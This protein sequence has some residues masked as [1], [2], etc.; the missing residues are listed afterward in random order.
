MTVRSV[1]LLAAGLSALTGQAADWPLYRGSLSQQGVSEDT[2]PADPV[3]LWSFK[4]EAPITSSPVVKDGT[5]VV[6][7][8]DGSVYA[9]SLDNGSKRWSFAT[10]ADVEAPPA[11]VD[12][13]VAVGSTDGFLYGLNLSDGALRWK[14]ETE[15]SILAAAVPLVVSNQVRIAVGSYDYR[16]HCVEA[17]GGKLLWTYE[18]D[19]YINGSPAVDRGQAVF[20]GCDGLLHVVDLTTGL[21]VKSVEVDAYIAGSAALVDG[22]AYFGHYGNRFVAIRVDDGTALWEYGDRDF[23]FFSAP[24]VGKDRVFFG[25]RDKRVHAVDRASGKGLWTFRTRGK[26]DSSPV[27]AGDRLVVGS[28][29]GRLYILDADTGSSVWSYDIASAIVGAPAV[30]DGRILVGAEDGTLYVFGRPENR[31]SPEPVSDQALRFHT[32]PKPLAPGAVTSEWPSF[33][34][35]LQAMKSLESPLL[36]DWG[37]G[38]PALVWERETGEGFSSPALAAGRLVTFHRIGDEDVV[39]CLEPATGRRYWSRRYETV[40]RDR[41]GYNG[42]PRASPCVDPP[43]V[44][45]YGVQGILH[46]FFLDSGD[47]AWRRDLNDEYQVPQDFFGVGSSPIVY[48]DWLLVNV[49][50]PGGPCLVAL[51]KETGKTV[52]S[53]GNDWGGGYA[54][55]V[56]A[57][58]HGRDHVLLFAGR[59]S[60][61]PVGGLLAIDLEQRETRFTF[62]W[63]STRVESVNASSPVVIDDRI[64]VSHGI[65]GKGAMVRSPVAGGA[66]TVWTNQH[67]GA[68]W[69]TP[70]YR[71]GYLYGVD[72]QNPSDASL[73]CLDAA[74]GAVEWRTMPSW[75]EQVGDR[76]L[77]LRVDRGNL[78]DADGHTLCLG[79]NGHLLWLDLTPRQC[80][81][82]T[83]TRL[84][85][86]PE[87]YAPPI[88]SKGLLYVSQN[89]PDRL[90]RTAPRLLCYDLRGS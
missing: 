79:E 13:L 24:A 3:L 82:L 35:P 4:T 36:K 17:E 44:F 65:R 5:V 87:T 2:I 71:D 11:I 56:V 32:P 67:L 72:G 83:R 31:P 7:S 40:Y 64:Y 10:E 86:A 45:T 85:L 52:W 9:L 58:L 84:F 61:P 78:L 42:G 74:T 39:D 28:E 77:T 69:M 88:L 6:G 54:T 15:D 73:V 43:R 76:S 27:L 80:S 46:A 14:Y 21:K 20:G 75:T 63:R 26:V 1:L 62:P 81:V 29:D 25:G 70:I 12:D 53:A 49:G 57:P 22:V 23:P 8:L 34:G 47:I 55:P 68:Y 48:G 18:T 51:D 30:A 37:E 59:D 38:G 16:L 41:Y 66:E 19:N 33:L 90:T 50:S 60:R 89:A